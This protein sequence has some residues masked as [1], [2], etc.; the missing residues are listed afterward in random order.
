MALWVFRIVISASSLLFLLVWF[1]MVIKE[2]S[3]KTSTEGQKHWDQ[4][5]LMSHFTTNFVFTGKIFTIFKLNNLIGGSIQ[6][7]NWD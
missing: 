3:R 2:F 4:N 5:F 6:P 7:N 1:D